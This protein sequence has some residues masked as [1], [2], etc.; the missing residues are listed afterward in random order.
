[1]TSLKGNLVSQSSSLSEDADEVRL[2]LRFL[3]FP[4][5]PPP[6]PIRRHPAVAVV[7]EAAEG[8]D[9]EGRTKRSWD[10]R[11]EVEPER[12]VAQKIWNG[13]K[14]NQFS[15]FLQFYVFFVQ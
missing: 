13:K 2:P 10:S 3:P 7:V 4:V 15:P 14:A 11:S 1:V 8:D 9:E 5:P 6:P 12:G